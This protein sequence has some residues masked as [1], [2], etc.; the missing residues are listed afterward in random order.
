MKF[1]FGG[2]IYSI[3]SVAGLVV[4]YEMINSLAQTA[5]KKMFTMPTESSAIK[6]AVQIARKMRSDGTRFNVELCP[7]LLKVKQCKN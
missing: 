4:E 6:A 2:A 3:V 7:E 5:E 1:Y